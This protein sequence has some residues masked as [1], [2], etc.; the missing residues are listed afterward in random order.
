MQSKRRN[1]ANHRMRFSKLLLMLRN[2]TAYL[3][4]V[5]TLHATA[6]KWGLLVLDLVSHKLHHHKQSWEPGD[7]D[8]LVNV[9]DEVFARAL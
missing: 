5:H 8:D 9:I 2:V 4:L 7:F 6:A 3:A 1:D